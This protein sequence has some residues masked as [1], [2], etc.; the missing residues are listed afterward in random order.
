MPARP[1]IAALAA[2]IALAAALAAPAAAPA[3]GEPGAGDS[4]YQDPFADPAPSA[5]DQGTGSPPQGTPQQ[6]AGQQDADRGTSTAGQAAPTP[7]PDHD[8]LP[9]SAANP[10][11]GT[12]DAAA[13]AARAGGETLPRTGFDVLP[14]AAAGVVLLLGGLAL[15]RR[16]SHA[17]D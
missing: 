4:Q 15:L 3:Q 10:A 17:R 2:V 7:T 9:P 1:R 8:A 11:A 16:A 14:V 6:G 13:A 12:A 5:G